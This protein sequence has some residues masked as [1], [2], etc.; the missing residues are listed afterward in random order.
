MQQKVDFQTEVSKRVAQH[1]CRLSASTS[2]FQ[3]LYEQVEASMEDARHLF[4][5]MEH[6]VIGLEAYQLKVAEMIAKK[7]EMLDDKERTLRATE[8]E[9]HT[10]RSDL[11]AAKRSLDE[12]SKLLEAE[13]S[14]LREKSS[15]LSAQETETS[16]LAEL[17]QQQSSIIAKDQET[18]S[19]LSSEVKN[20]RES[21]STI[22]DL[23]EVEVSRNKTEEEIC[24]LHSQIA[25]LE[26]RIDKSNAARSKSAA[27]SKQLVDSLIQERD[28]AFATLA[29][30]ERRCD[31]LEKENM[32]LRTLVTKKNPL[33]IQ[34]TPT[35]ARSGSV[36]SSM[37]ST[38]YSPY[39]SPHNLS[40]SSYG[41][42]P[43]TAS[44][45]RSRISTTA[46]ASR[47]D[48]NDSVMD[49]DDD[50][51]S[52]P[53]VFGSRA[54]TPDQH[55]RSA[56]VVEEDSFNAQPFDLLGDASNELSQYRGLKCCR[57]PS[58]GITIACTSCGLKSHAHC[59]DAQRAK[60]L[61][62]NQKFICFD[63]EQLKSH[64]SKAP[65]TRLNLH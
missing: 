64:S 18:I 1:Y 37:N 33:S 29:T 30:A 54:F 53:R 49:V 16:K 8:G 15:Q 32:D 22:K 17:L 59:I 56:M 41:S 50:S 11:I 38:P 51:P 19:T 58:L 39:R 31:E 21:A 60:P 65:K 52:H 46:Q 35:Q 14:L 63:C 3:T 48:L 34:R 12:S 4:A 5:N 10:L 24:E 44:S 61:R 40:T 20:L 26:L 28:S 7:R 55:Q 9:L 36:S 2:H 45:Q 25:V 47:S 62:K 42:V 13:R 43:S 57:E 27:Q 23:G 6:Q